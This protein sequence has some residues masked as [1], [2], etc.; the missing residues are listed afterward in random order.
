MKACRVTF[1]R[2]GLREFWKG[3]L[4]DLMILKPMARWL[5]RGDYPSKMGIKDMKRG[6]LEVLGFWVFGVLGLRP[7]KRKSSND[8]YNFKLNMLVSDSQPSLS[9]N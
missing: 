8:P 5:G 2:R 4:E 7:R 9:R 6:S 1:G 3:R